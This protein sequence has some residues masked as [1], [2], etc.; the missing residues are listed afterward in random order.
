MA[1]QE[2]K[3]FR[4]AAKK[5]EIRMARKANAAT[6]IG[7]LKPG[8]EIFVL[9][10]GQFSLIEA[11]DALL[12]QTGPAEVVLS[13]WTAGHADLT[14]SAKLLEAAAITRFRLIVDSSFLNRK[15]EWC[16]HMLKVFGE[17]CIRVWRGHAKFAVIRNEKWNLAVRTS[18]NLNT[19]PRLENLEISDDPEFS[20]FLWDVVESHFQ[21]EA[22]GYDHEE[23]RLPELS[24]MR[25]TV[26]PVQ[27]EMGEITNVG[28][29]KI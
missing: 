9:T 20:G 25:D 5:R 18:M 13:T 14:K 15:P 2:A 16:A 7:E 11:I 1:S 26:D 17:D 23:W 12:E 22:P 4:R 24:E 29:V 21:D 3:A 6:A 19:N 8:A 10:Y 28:R 27:I